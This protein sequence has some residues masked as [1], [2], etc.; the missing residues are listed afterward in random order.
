MSLNIR[1]RHKRNE[2][3]N[4]CPRLDNVKTRRISNNILEKNCYISVILNKYWQI[5]LGTNKYL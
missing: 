4:I 5:V 1:F 3:K 2:A